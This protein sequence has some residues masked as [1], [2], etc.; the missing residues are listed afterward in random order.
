[1]RASEIFSPK[2]ILRFAKKVVGFKWHRNI[3]DLD[4]DD[5]VQN[6]CRCVYGYKDTIDIPDNIVDIADKRK[7]LIA[8]MKNRFKH[9]V[10]RADFDDHLRWKK[11]AKKKGIKFLSLEAFETVDE[12]GNMYNPVEPE[13]K[14]F[15]AKYFKVTEKDLQEEVM[16]A[17]LNYMET[18]EADTP[19]HTRTMRR[20][21]RVIRGFMNDV[22]VEV[23]AEEERFKPPFIYT[24]LS[25]F[26]NQVRWNYY[27]RVPCGLEPVYDIWFDKRRFIDE[28]NERRTVSS[29]VTNFSKRV[30]TAVRC[31]NEGK[32]LWCVPS[33]NGI[34]KALQRL[35]LESS[36]YMSEEEVK[37]FD[38]AS[39]KLYE[40]V[41]NLLK[42][43]QIE[44]LDDVFAPFKKA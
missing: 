28:Y 16:L 30:D 21:A 14:Y 18:C 17:T 40:L 31:Y 29:A 44:F 11:R 26:C 35:S 24:I 3:V 39:K 19:A 7:Y 32:T 9:V 27:W 41:G 15:K 43:D 12:Q 25:Q 33:L 37:T 5:A 1:M 38:D 42:T 36:L 23:I 2:E 22:D 6:L 13:T 20:D 4:K 10:E 34:V 8:C